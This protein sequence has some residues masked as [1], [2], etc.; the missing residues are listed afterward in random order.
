MCV[1]IYVY[2]YIYG[3][4]VARGNS[5]DVLNS[6]QSRVVLVR[7]LMVLETSQVQQLCVCIKALPG[8]VLMRAH[9][10]PRVSVHS[11]PELCGAG[12]QCAGPQPA[13]AGE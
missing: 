1:Y 9:D 3:L 12:G 4:L 8:G 10:E 5:P 2:I 13:G 7:L 11:A 6:K